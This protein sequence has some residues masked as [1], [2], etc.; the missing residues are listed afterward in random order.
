MIAIGNRKLGGGAPCLIIAELGTSHQGETARGREL[1]EAAAAAGAEC[2]KL[3]LVHAEEILHPLAGEVELPTGRVELYKRFK[4]LEKE[5]SF[6]RDLKD[7]AEKRGLIFLCSAFGPR[8]ARELAEMGVQALK[9]AS[10]ELNHF[11]LLRQAR[12]YGIPLILSTG[13]STL[14]D[15]ERALDVAGRNLVLLHCVT[16]YPAPEGEYNLRLVATLGNIFGVQTGVSDHSLDPVLV[17]VLAVFNGACMIEKQGAGL[18]DPIAL[19]PQEFARMTRRVREAERDGT[20]ARARLRTEYGDA[21]V[22]EAEGNG[23]KA[24]APSEKANYRRTNRSIHA[25]N[26]IPEGALI[27]EEMVGVL[28]TEKKLRPGI[29]PEFLSLVIG[30]RAKRPIPAGEGVLWEDLI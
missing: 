13:V 20:S 10:P 16:A 1:I 2:V 8:S 11:P 29:G 28:R 23:V 4:E 30:A 18:D 15:I 12:G 6:Y 19:P 22:R 17:P 7:Y 27:T 5:V 25:M 9:I 24:L 3:Q 21:R 14:S 26:E